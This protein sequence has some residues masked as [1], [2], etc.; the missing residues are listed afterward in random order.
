MSPSFSP[1]NNAPQPANEPNADSLDKAIA[2]FHDIEMLLHKEE[3]TVRVPLRAILDAIPAGARSATMPDPGSQ[4]FALHVPNL[5]YQLTKGKVVVSLAHLATALPPGY[6]TAEAANDEETQ[7]RL[8]LPVIVSAVDPALLRER[9]ASKASKI[10]PDGI[11]DPF[12]RK[13]APAA[14]SVS[15]VRPPPAPASAPAMPT[16]PPTVEA[17][18]PSIGPVQPPASVP[19]PSAPLVRPTPIPPAETMVQPVAAQPSSPPLQ[20][21]SFPP[22]QPTPVP[23][24]SA[25]VAAPEPARALGEIVEPTAA[26]SVAAP[27]SVPPKPAR[28]P[29]KPV[30]VSPEE[31]VGVEEFPGPLGVNI[32]SA[33]IEQLLQLEGMTAALAEGIVAYRTAHGPFGNIFDLIN[34]PRLGRKTFRHITGMP[35]NAARRHRALKLARLVHLPVAKVGHLPSLTA[36]IASLPGF[37]G[38]V[39]ADSDGLLLAQSGADERAPILS[40]IAPKIVAQVEAHVALLNAGKLRGVSLAA[41]HHLVTFA[42]RG[43]IYLVVLHEKEKLTR[44]QIV[45]IEK[46]VGELGWLLSRRVYVGR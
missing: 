45:C 31:E 23:P 44:R 28:P 20:H 36:A 27:P 6:L 5:F 18:T 39:I 21:P 4:T 13:G 10:R 41:A 15:S 37:R 16:P 40:G 9:T 3:E 22:Q 29:R 43:R 12:A 8:P 17:T 46:I 1:R 19:P 34:V 2:A 7:V 33:S 42:S 26:P 14:P 11:P 32:N 35:Y 25:P 38:C 30:P 24:P